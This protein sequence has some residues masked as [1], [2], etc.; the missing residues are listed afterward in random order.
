M[1]IAIIGS[2]GVGG[3]FGARLAQADNE[4]HFVARGAHLDAMKKNG[5]KV[6]SALGDL[7]LSKVECTDDTASI[8][9]VDIAMIAVKL[10]STEDAA[11]AAKPLIGKNTAVV[12][13][14]NGVIAVDTLVSVLGREHVMGGVANIAALIEEPGVIRHNGNMANLFF[15]ELDGK[16]SARAKS[17]L[18]ACLKAKIQAE[19]PDDIH[20][21]IW[22][23]FVRL[24]TMSAMTTLTRVPV[25]PIRE[26]PDT[27]AMMLQV[28]EEVIA[29]GRKHGAKFPQDITTDQF[30][31]ID[32]YPPTMVASMCGDLRRGNRLELP[33]LSGTVARLGKELGIP[34][35]ANQFV[36]AALKLHADGRHPQA[37]V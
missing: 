19:I 24:V 35:P 14:Q 28:M 36:Y 8:G 26:D 30:K 27:R 11:R 34:T 5:L 22:E 31:K 10:W 33:W 12:S 21:A 32:G 16:S 6:L 7:H 37:Q 18:D 23:K 29:I 20:T 2:G 13:F 4:V 1:K 25:G 17:L 3:Y 9:P 15:A